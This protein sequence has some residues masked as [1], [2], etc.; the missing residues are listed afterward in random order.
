MKRIFIAI[1]T[2]PEALLQRMYESLRSVLGNEKITWVNLENFHLTLVFLGD[3]EEEKIKIA[4]IVLKQKCTAFGEFA[5]RLSGTGVF[6]NLNDPRVLWLGIEDPVKLIELNDQIYNGLS[7]AGIKIED[8][9]FKPHLT[10]GRIKSIK[11]SEAFRSAISQ[12]QYTF[13]QEILVREVT[14]YESILKPT[15]PIYRAAGIFGLK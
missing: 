2:E 15:G 8:Q 13:F 3:T 12:Y 11:D 10:I 6:K 1:K 9:R 14:L 7:E 4:S 5:F